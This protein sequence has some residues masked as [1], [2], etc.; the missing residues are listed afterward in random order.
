M[1]QKIPPIAA[2]AE[3]VANAMGREGPGGKAFARIPSW[4]GPAKGHGVQTDKPRG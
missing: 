1:L 3:N 2:P 4:W